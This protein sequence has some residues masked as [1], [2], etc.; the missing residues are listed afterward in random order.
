MNISEIV[1]NY[2]YNKPVKTVYLFG[3][4]LT[5]ELNANDID[6][7]LELDYNFNITLF[8]MGKWNIELENIFH[9]KIDL[10]T[11][12]SINSHIKPFIEAQKKLIFTNQTYA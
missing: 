7:L 2:F 9:K 8:D 10:L 5:D 1:N 12:E 6:L 11:T 3:S 4:A